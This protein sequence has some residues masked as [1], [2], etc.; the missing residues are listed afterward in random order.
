MSVSGINDK[1]RLRLSRKVDECKPLAV[2]GDILLF[3]QPGS[4]S[5]FP[6]PPGGEVPVTRWGQGLTLVPNSAQLEPLCP[7]YNPN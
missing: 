4:E 3:R 1:K 2:G 5:W 7:P 6:L